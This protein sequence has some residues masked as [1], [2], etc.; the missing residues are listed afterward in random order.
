[1]GRFL[2]EFAVAT[3]AHCHAIHRPLAN[4][5]EALEKIEKQ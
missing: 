4:L 1:V 3:C 5:R 2:G